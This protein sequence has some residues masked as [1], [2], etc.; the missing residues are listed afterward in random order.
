MQ[1]M[2][3][4]DL[5]EAGLRLVGL[6]S[7][8]AAVLTLI[9][10]GPGSGGTGTG[11]STILG[12]ATF[13]SSS[14]ASISAP[15]PSTRL[16]LEPSLLEL[17]TGCVR[18]HHEGSWSVDENNQSTTTG[19]VEISSLAGSRITNGSLRLV[20][21]GP[22]TGQQVLTLFDPL[23]VQQ[24]TFT[25]FDEAGRVVLGPQTLQRQDGAPAP[26]MGACS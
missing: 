5:L 2:K 20:F 10:C 6:L 11:P 3:T 1:Q 14:S 25:L 15:P 8:L 24:V 23:S 7:V 22:P 19:I 16:R 4:R 12:S 18:F 9:S 13:A 17:S 21:V 26:V